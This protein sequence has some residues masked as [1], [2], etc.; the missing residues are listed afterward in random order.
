MTELPDVPGETSLDKVFPTKEY[1]GETIE[2]T[3]L[4]KIQKGV[5]LIVE[6]VMD[7]ILEENHNDNKD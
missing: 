4:T 3:Y 7:Q 5:A 6:G 1:Q 2:V